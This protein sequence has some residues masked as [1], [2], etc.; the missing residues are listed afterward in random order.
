V[1]IANTVTLDANESVYSITINSSKTLTVSSSNTLTVYHNFTNN[2]TFTYSTGT[3]TFA[4]SVNQTIGGSSTTT[5]YNLTANPSASSDTVSLSKAIHVN[6]NFTISEGVFACATYSITGNSTGTMSMASGTTLVL[7]LTSSSTLPGFP[8]TFTTAHISLDA[9]ST[10]VYQ[11]NNTSTGQTV[12]GTPYYGN[13]LVTTSSAGTSAVSKSWIKGNLTIGSG[14]TFKNNTVNW[15]T[16]KGNLIINSGAT[17]DTYSANEYLQGNVTNN[18]TYNGSYITYFEGSTN[19]VLSGVSGPINS[20]FHSL[21]LIPKVSTDTTFIEANIST[22]YIANSGTLFVPAAYNDTIVIES[23]NNLGTITALNGVAYILSGVLNDNLCSF[24]KMTVGSNTAQYANI[25]VASD[26]T[27]LAGTYTI[28]S[29]TLNVGGNYVS[30][31][32]TVTATVVMNGSHNQTISGTSSAIGS[33]QINQSALTDTVTLGSSINVYNVTIT[34]GN[35]N[36]GS[37]NYNLTFL[38][39]WTN[40][41]NFIPGN[42]TVTFG[43]PNGN[44]NIAGTSVTTFNNFTVNSSSSYALVLSDNVIIKGNLLL[45]TGILDVSSSNYSVTLG[46]NFTNNAATNG[47]NARSGLL[48]LNGSGNQTIGGTYTTSFYNLTQKQAASTDTLFLGDSITVNHNLADSS[49]VFDCQTH[50]IKG[51]TSGTFT[52]ASGTNMLLGSVSSSTNVTFPTLFTTAHTTLNAGS[53]IS[54]L[55][56]TAQTIS[57]TPTYGNLVLGSGSSVTRKT[58]ASTTLAV[59]GNLNVNAN[60]TL[61]ENTGTLNLTGNL[62]NAD[63]VLFTTGAMNIGGTFTNNGYYAYG[64][65][66]ATFNGSTNAQ[67]NGTNAPTFYN[68]TL[69]KSAATDTLFLT[70]PIAVNNTLTI[71]QGVLDCKGNQLTN[72]ATPAVTLSPTSATICNGSSTSLSA[73]GYSS[74][75]WYPSTGLTATTGSSVTANPSAST[76]YTVFAVVSKQ[77]QCALNA[78]GTGGITVNPTPTLNI[79]TPSATIC[80]SGGETV[81]NASGASTYTWGPSTGLSATTGATVDANPTSTTTYTVTGTSSYSCSSTA[82]KTITVVTCA[83]TSCS[84]NISVPNEV[85]DSDFAFPIGDTVMWFSFTPDSTIYEI[86]LG[87][88][89]SSIDTPACSLKGIYLYSGACG[90]LTRVD[91]NIITSGNDTLPFI[92]YRN[93]TPH[94]Q[95]FVKATRYLP[96]INSAYFSYSSMSFSSLKGILPQYSCGITACGPNLAYN[97][98]FEMYPDGGAGAGHDPSYNYASG[99]LCIPNSYYD[100]SYI[101]S[102]A[103][104]A[105]PPNTTGASVEKYPIGSPN[106]RYL[107]GYIDPVTAINVTCSFTGTVVAGIHSKD[108]D[109]TDMYQIVHVNDLP[110]L[111][112]SASAASGSYFLAVDAPSD[113]CKE[114]SNFRG[115][116]FGPINNLYNH[117]PYGAIAWSD[118]ISG[119]AIG[120]T[121]VLTFSALALD[122]SDN[123][124]STFIIPFINNAKLGNLPLADGVVAGT[125]DCS[126]WAPFTMCYTANTTTAIVQ[127]FVAGGKAAN[128]GDI[129]ID[130]IGFALGNPAPPTVSPSNPAICLGNNTTLTASATGATGYHWAPSG[131]LSATT[132][133]TVTASPTV[134]TTYSVYYTISGCSNN[135]NPQTVVVTVNPNPT[136]T[137][138]SAGPVPVCASL[139]DALTASGAITYTWTP[140]LTLSAST[141]TTVNAN[142]TSTVTYNVIGTDANGCVSPTATITVVGTTNCCTPSGAAYVW[143]SGGTTSTIPATTYTNVTLPIAI[144][145]TVQVTGNVIFE[146]CPDIRMDANSEIDVM[147]GGSLTIENYGSTISRLWA[148]SDM[149]NGIVVSPSSGATAAG[150]L[151]VSGGTII[152]DAKKGIEALSAVSPVTPPTITVANSILNN[153]HYDVYI[154]GYTNTGTIYPLT[155]QGDSLTTS[156]D[157]TYSGPSL[158]SP[159]SGII[160][161]TGVQVNNVPNKSVMIGTL[162][163]SSTN[164]FSTMNFGIQASDADIWVYN[165]KFWNMVGP[166]KLCGGTPIGEGVLANATSPGHVIKVG[167]AQTYEPNTF[168]NVYRGVDIN[169]YTLI[170]I[171]NNTFG[172]VNNN[173]SYCQPLLGD[174]AVYIKTNKAQVLEVDSNTVI[175]YS[176]GIHLTRTLKIPNWTD[177]EHV[178]YNNLS[179]AGSGAM[180]TGILVENGPNRTTFAPIFINFNTVYDALNCIWVKNMMNQKTWVDSNEY[181]RIRAIPAASA[182]SK[183]ERSGIRIENCWGPGG[184][185]LVQSNPNIYTNGTYLTPGSGIVPA[186][187]EVVGINVLYSRGIVEQCNNIYSVGECM[188]FT[189]N[190][191]ANRMLSNSFGISGASYDGFVLWNNALLGVQGYSPHPSGNTWNNPT[192]NFLR[193]ETYVENAS[194]SNAPLDVSSG[195]TTDPTNN[196]S[197]PTGAYTSSDLIIISGTAL[198]CGSS[199]PSCPNNHS[200]IMDSIAMDSMHYSVY[201]PYTKQINQQMVFDEVATYDSLRT[202]D[203]NLNKFYNN[204]VSD[205]MGKLYTINNYL[206][207]TSYDEAK[208][209]LTSFTPT[210]TIEANYK[211]V[212]SI[213]AYIIGAGVYVMDSLDSVHLYRI[214]YQCP[215]MGGMA[216]YQARTMLNLLTNSEWEFSDSCTTAGGRVGHKHTGPPVNNN[217]PQPLVSKNAK[218]YPNPANSLLNIEVQLPQGTTYEVCMY[219]TLGEKVICE[220]LSQNLTTLPIN[221]LTSGIYYYRIT[222]AVGTLVKADKIMIVH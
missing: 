33:I 182:N 77:Y 15:D 112:N 32:G 207:S 73:S 200:P 37:S 146:G 111:F 47:F 18:G 23:V 193:S 87:F 129:G 164:T 104:P 199:C 61:V 48:K 64:T 12:S 109:F 21:E 142:P 55:A 122:A 43:V 185:F 126:S 34:Q 42:G 101:F 30:N 110:A 108:Y 52:M 123:G 168:A 45:T 143:G 179:I 3:V 86:A 131:G 159:Y 17:Y 151:S 162:A 20:I 71:T 209:A 1:T 113:G 157:G 183:T 174:H 99:N 211:T 102:T 208:T 11:A 177:V 29:G 150:I 117:I 139:Y 124:S 106:M 57:T 50:K 132:G 184:N 158:K 187:T 88:P 46:G 212:D 141:G 120:A 98:N 166:R 213:Y 133:A 100:V 176:T 79:T 74:Y 53:T 189:G 9:A 167:A 205:N 27:I 192:T 10:V 84:N 35:L 156:L 118:T 154:D 38:H 172:T 58:P 135:S 51:N 81:L 54:Y 28:T 16:I 191:V 163:A 178:N 130:S 173:S 217:Q 95:Y 72:S 194:A 40:N 25:A 14:V 94:S 203:T 121:Y 161:Y 128:G 107:T 115:S 210:D 49:G 138:T 186:D 62:T 78:G 70:H 75:T 222:D 116:P 67:V 92:Y 80:A 188:R 204:N 97:G 134:T 149:W 44:M 96:Q 170:Q 83:G 60:T 190:C 196:L 215:D 180:N 82:T 5:F 69:N 219:S 85:N 63:T 7:G 125:Y 169:N 198:G 214:A 19:Q 76:T 24:H 152:E 41:A 8:S 175:N 153:N 4:G 22:I 206:D 103:S 148:C 89:K 160:T 93:L 90:S 155:L 195:I 137:V 65:G 39:E 171:N 201:A 145:G 91:S 13:L 140:S 220:E 36:G 202:G 147:P 144:S 2:G 68:F 127:L 136:V 26:L 6:N 165:N 105:T 119:L 181:L 216:V 66:T 56:N 114:C 31:G 197:F 221:N 59:A 218:V